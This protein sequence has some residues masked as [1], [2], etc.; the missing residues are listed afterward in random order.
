MTKL[1]DEPYP[2]LY[3]IDEDLRVERCPD[4]SSY[5]AVFLHGETP[6]IMG[7]DGSDCGES[8]MFP[9]EGWLVHTGYQLT[10]PPTHWKG[11][12]RQ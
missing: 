6:R 3:R 12:F 7:I 5:Y 2:R 1:A 10:S 8:W 9:E 11:L 4:A